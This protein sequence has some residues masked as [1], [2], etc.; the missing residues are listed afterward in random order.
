MTKRIL[1]RGKPDNMFG[2]GLKYHILYHRSRTML[3]WG[4]PNCGHGSMLILKDFV[5]EQVSEDMICKH[6]LRGPSKF[7]QKTF[8]G[9]RVPA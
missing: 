9:I 3:G 2:K 6:C 8:E 7:V 5:N 4:V 1:I